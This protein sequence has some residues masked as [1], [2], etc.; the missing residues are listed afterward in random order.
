MRWDAAKQQDLR[1][2]AR[3]LIAAWLDGNRMIRQRP[4]GGRWFY[5]EKRRR[6]RLVF[7]RHGVSRACLQGLRVG[8]GIPVVDG[9]CHAL[10][11]F[12]S[13]RA[14]LPAC[15]V[16]QEESPA[17]SGAARP[18]SPRGRWGTGTAWT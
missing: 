18:W 15:L 4:L 3:P 13:G 17:D 1:Y 16:F 6:K 7:A 14:G 5:R 11:T 8:Q 9:I 2:D 12:M 10:Y